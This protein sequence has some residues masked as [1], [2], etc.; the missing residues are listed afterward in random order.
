MRNSSTNKDFVRGI[1]S[2][3]TS[4]PTAFLREKKM[5]KKDRKEESIKSSRRLRNRGQSLRIKNLYAA[6]IW[7]LDISGMFTIEEDN[8]FVM[9]EKRSRKMYTTW[10]GENFRHV[11]RVRTQLKIGLFFEFH[12]SYYCD[13]NDKSPFYAEKWRWKNFWLLFSL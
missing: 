2:K 7:F 10:A 9:N 4:F 8:Q 13:M 5:M 12:V 3:F 6:N 1:P 11:F